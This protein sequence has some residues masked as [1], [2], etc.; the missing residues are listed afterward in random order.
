MILDSVRGRLAAWHTAV[1]A[2]VLV[3]FS[4]ATYAF[5]VELTRQRT[6]R[7]LVD[8]ARAFH[9]TFISE[10]VI[11]IT[12]DAAARPSSRTAERGTPWGAA[13]RP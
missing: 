1:L 12:P 6:D 2:L 5:L 13:G 3:A 9:H 8:T 11:E 7:L 10:L 4:A